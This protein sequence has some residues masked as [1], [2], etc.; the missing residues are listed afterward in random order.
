MWSEER[1]PAGQGGTQ[2][3]VLRL[4]VK[5]VVDGKDQNDGVQ[6]TDVSKQSDNLHEKRYL[7]MSSDNWLAHET[8]SCKVNHQGKEFTQTE[9]I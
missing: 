4:T 5:W 2:L 6:S 9:E 3:T 7:S 1:A 8:Y